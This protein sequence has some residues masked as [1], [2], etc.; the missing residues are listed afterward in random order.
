MPPL[1]QCQFLNRLCWAK[2][3]T[4]IPELQDMAIPFAPERELL[5]LILKQLHE[6]DVISPILQKKKL[7]RRFNSQPVP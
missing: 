6:R 7:R 4:R 5:L 2:D 3:R 1:Q